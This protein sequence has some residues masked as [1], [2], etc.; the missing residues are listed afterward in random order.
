MDLR[1]F[2]NKVKITQKENI[3]FL[4]FENSNSDSKPGE[5]T[6]YQ[7]EPGW[8]QLSKEQP[9]IPFVT[10]LDNKII[11]LEYLKNQIETN[12]ITL[13]RSSKNFYI[14]LGCSS[15]FLV[16]LVLSLFWVIK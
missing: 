16:L 14:V 10:L 4:D 9:N 2:R 12:L 5:N 7:E 11:Q 15:F 6:E 1:K 3:F 8:L 13:Q